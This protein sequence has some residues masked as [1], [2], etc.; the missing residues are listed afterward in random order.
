ML[1]SLVMKITV[2]LF[3]LESRSRHTEILV[4]SVIADEIPALGSLLCHERDNLTMGLNFFDGFGLFHKGVNIV[5]D[6]D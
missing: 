3:P 1:V 5:H 4:H 6:V 2:R